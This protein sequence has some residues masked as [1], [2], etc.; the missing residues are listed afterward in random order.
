LCPYTT[1]F[2]SHNSL[3]F[4]T[5][6]FGNGDNIPGFKLAAGKNFLRVM[7]MKDILELIGPDINYGH[8][9][10]TFLIG[11]TFSSRKPALMVF[12][13]WH[14]FFI[15][16]AKINGSCENIEVDRAALGEGNKTGRSLPILHLDLNIG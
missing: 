12:D 11:Q 14:V 8:F 13:V 7:F 2:R 5:K 3:F 9:K 15:A 16:A 10:K 6:S 1:L 4:I